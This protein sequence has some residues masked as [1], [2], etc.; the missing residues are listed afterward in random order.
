[1]KRSSLNKKSKITRR[2]VLIAG[3][4]VAGAAAAMQVAGKEAEAAGVTPA[5]TADVS[6]GLAIAA[7]DAMFQ[8]ALVELQAAGFGFDLSPLAAQFATVQ[9]NLVG[10]V[11]KHNLSLSNRFGVDLI[12]TADLEAGTL[13][14]LQWVIGWSLVDSLE[15]VSDVFDSRLPLKAEARSPRVQYATPPLMIRPRIEQSWSF[16]RPGSPPIQPS[17]LVLTGWP[18]GPEALNSGYWHYGGCSAATWVSD[19]LALYYLASQLSEH[20]GGTQFRYLDLLY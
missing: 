19:G 2:E 3:A 7:G 15:V 6:T 8:E 5:T 10:M 18:P 20:L 4:T 16:W 14:L 13:F 17:D 12:L 9:D 11:I 1:M